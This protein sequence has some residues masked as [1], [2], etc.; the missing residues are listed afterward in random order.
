MN[1]MNKQRNNSSTRRRS[2]GFTLLEVLITLL[3]ISIGLLGLAG[4]QISGMRANQMGF[5][6]S[7]AILAAYD[8]ADRMRANPAAAAAG[9]YDGNPSAATVDCVGASNACTSAEMASYDKDAWLD[10][11][12]LLPGGA[13]EVVDDGSDNYTITVRW[14]EERS[15]ATGTDCPPKADTDLRCYSL[16]IA[17]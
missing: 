15:G 12:T 13:G 10:I 14:D 11:L 8:M 6:R 1:K 3:V 2:R 7:Q 9:N 4:L 5:M 17:L 16:G